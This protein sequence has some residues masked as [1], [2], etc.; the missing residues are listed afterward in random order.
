M[1]SDSQLKKIE[2]VS[3]VTS[4]RFW[5]HLTPLVIQLMASR[6]HEHQGVL[7]TSRWLWE[8]TKGLMILVFNF[9]EGPTVNN[10]LEFSISNCV[11]ELFAA[12][13]ENPLSLGPNTQPL[14]S[15]FSDKSPNQNHAPH[16]TTIVVAFSVAMSPELLLF[17]ALVLVKTKLRVNQ[18]C[19]LRKT[20]REGKQGL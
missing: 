8:Q 12:K 16:N 7:V 9:H 10:H 17:L 1:I 15:K 13:A 5:V 3:L 19:S 14:P 2:F 11:L 6:W 4:L 18:V 20:E